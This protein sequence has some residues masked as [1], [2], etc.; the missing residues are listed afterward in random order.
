MPA[1]ENYDFDDSLG[2][3]AVL[4]GWP[5]E[6]EIS[7][8]PLSDSLTAEEITEE[9]PA[10]TI[11]ISNSTPCSAGRHGGGYPINVPPVLVSSMW[12]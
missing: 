4:G 3:I 5:R 7:L 2:Q 10:R 1:S 12:D 8:S 11:L 9:V 6:R